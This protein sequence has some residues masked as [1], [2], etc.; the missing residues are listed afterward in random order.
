MFILI[1]VITLARLLD[2]IVVGRNILSSSIGSAA[3]VASRFMFEDSC[4]KIHT[5]TKSQYCCTA[6]APTARASTCVHKGHT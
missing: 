1:R 3:S 4:L 5:Q 6:S 2:S